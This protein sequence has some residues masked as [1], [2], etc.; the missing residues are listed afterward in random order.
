M[1]GILVP[2]LL[3]CPAERPPVAVSLT[4][5]RPCQPVHNCVRTQGGRGRQVGAEGGGGGGGRRWEKKFMA[6][7]VPPLNFAFEDLSAR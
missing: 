1:D 4:D 2:Y 7:C 5:G 6:V 3:N